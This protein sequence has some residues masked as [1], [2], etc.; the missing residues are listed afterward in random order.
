MENVVARVAVTLLTILGIAFVGTLGYSLY[1]YYKIQSVSSDI[2]MLITNA[3]GA[4]S[5]N[6]N[7]YTN[8]TNANL[9]GMNN[10]GLF[11][12][13][14]VRAAGLMDAWGNDV[15]LGSA[16]GATQGSVQF[17][18]GGSETSRQC[19][20][21]VTTLKDYVSLTVGGQAFTQDNLPDSVSA[22]TACAADPT[23]TVV[24][25]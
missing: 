5:Q 16:S 24:F 15:T 9:T 7:G 12:P 20:G 17:G 22:G 18:G 13:D 1:S 25:Q 14:M 21:V 2:N 23:I 19:A 10:A 11:P 4:F 3:R 8:F 6:A